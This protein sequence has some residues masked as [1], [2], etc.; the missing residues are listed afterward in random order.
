MTRMV[1]KNKMIE[2]VAALLKLVK[3]DTRM[4]VALPV[5]LLWFWASWVLAD[6]HRQLTVQSRPKQRS[7]PAAEHH[8]VQR[9]AAV[10]Q[11]DAFFICVAL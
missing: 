11:S 5:L 6:P 10:K 1:N 7:V 4:F 8:P 9:N 2:H 3:Q